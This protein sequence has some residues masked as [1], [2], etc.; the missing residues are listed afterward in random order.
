MRGGEGNR[1][2]PCWREGRS[3]EPG[4]S[5]LERG[6]ERSVFGEVVSGLMEK[7]MS[8]DVSHW[9]DSVLTMR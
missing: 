7:V 9:E 2:V 8:A 3:G 1:E 5:L 6:E 4:G